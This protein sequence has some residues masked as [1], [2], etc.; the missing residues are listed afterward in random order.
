MSLFN[1][2]A[3]D[4]ILQYLDSSIINLA[5]DAFENLE[6]QDTHE[7]KKFLESQYDIRLENLLEAK[8]VSI[9]HLESA[10]KNKIIQRKTTI[11]DKALKQ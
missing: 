1:E 3:L 5:N 2:K 10:M 8:N 4:E 11:T 9:H 6:M 7:I